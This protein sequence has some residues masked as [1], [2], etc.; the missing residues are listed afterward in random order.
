MV[1]VDF[2]IIP[3]E[4]YTAHKLQGKPQFCS[5]CPFAYNIVCARLRILGKCTGRHRFSTEDYTPLSLIHVVHAVRGEV[6]ISVSN[7]PPN[8][9]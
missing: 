6:W 5:I 1:A 7:T 9:P 3:R 4:P 2:S 8:E